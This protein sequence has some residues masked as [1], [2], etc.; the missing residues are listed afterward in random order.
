MPGAK[1]T[2]QRAGHHVQRLGVPHLLPKPR[3]LQ[4]IGRPAHALGTP[5]QRHVSITQHQHLRR[6]DNRLRA[7]PAKPI[8]VHRHGPLGHPGIH[9]GHTAEIHVARLG[10]QHMAKNRCANL[11]RLNARTGN[12]GLC[13]MGGQINRRQGGKAAAKA[14]N[15]SAGGGKDIDIGHGFTLSG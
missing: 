2:G 1:R 14:A 13:S 9:C 7:R 8:D 5:G 15:R 12:G 3:G 11:A 10:V 4:D 6:R